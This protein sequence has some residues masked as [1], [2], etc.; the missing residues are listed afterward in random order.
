MALIAL[1]LLLLAGADPDASAEAAR[2]N[3]S[4]LRA[5]AAGRAEEALLAF[6]EAMRLEPG[7]PR[8]RRNAAAASARLAETE[9]QEGRNDPAIDRWDEAV[10]L[11]P[12]R[13]AYR[14]GRAA[15]RLQR[16]RDADPLH[17][18]DDLEWALR[19]DPDHFEAL[20]RLGGLDYAER[21]LEEA[22]RR[23]RRALELAPEDEPLRRRLSEAEREWEVERSY[24]ELRSR[25]FVVRHG[26]SIPRDVAGEAMRFCE[27]AFGE[28][29]ARF[30]AHPGQPTVV[31]LYPPREF[32]Q[33][34]GAHA[35]VAGLSDGTIRV[36]VPQG[37]GALRAL[38]AILYHEYAHHL[39]RSLAPRAPR[40]LHEGLAQGAAGDALDA[41]ESRL[42]ESPPEPAVL[43]GDLVRSADGDGVRRFY[44]AALSFT[45]F[46][47]RE[48][49]DPGIQAFLRALREGRSEDEAL[50]LVYGEP[51]ER[52]H[53]R[54]R[55]GL[56]GS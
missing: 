2:A 40:W 32:R 50:Q 20:S 8:P 19:R 56:L 53:A 45:E 34:T 17:A 11:H 12:E 10:R 1:L 39:V 54:W 29:G 28:L 47:R 3:A 36:A 26:P 13:I 23:W 30:G 52:L 43:A 33:A 31:L 16:G 25:F 15:A 21:R 27:E 51:L 48:A 46:L 55:T 44:D 22:I 14:V 5:L 24:E 4:G 18:R 9:R 38:R 49:G 35:W 7:D 6:R 41:A 42:R 37:G